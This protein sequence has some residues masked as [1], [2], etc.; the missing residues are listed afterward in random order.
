MAIEI[1]DFTVTI[2]AGTAIAAGFTS[3][4]SFPARVVTEIHVRVPPGPRGEVGFA[5][6]SGGVR[7]IPYGPGAWIVTDD[8]DL[9]YPL[10]ATIDSGAWQLLA[11]N[12]G[13]FAHTLRIYFYC[14]LLGP[15]PVGSS[16]TPI[17]TGDLGSGT[18][19]GTGTGGDTGGGSGTGVP[20]ISPPT[21]TPPSPGAGGI[22]LPLILPPALPALPGQGAAGPVPVPDAL[23]IAVGDAG[24]VGLLMD[25]AYWPLQVQDDVTGLSDGGVV[26]IQASAG[27]DAN[28]RAGFP[29]GE[30]GTPPAGTGGTG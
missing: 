15:A 24:T 9:T 5:I 27:M 29:L 12:T 4:M 30:A 20:I 28:L 23:L 7:I 18:G 13:S 25:G 26:G 19:S 1:R 11:Y 6:G 16:F 3:D 17:P 21:I 22:T 2:P 8:E 14:E 10:T